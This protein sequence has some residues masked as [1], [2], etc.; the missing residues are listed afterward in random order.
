MAVMIFGQASSAESQTRFKHIPLQYI[1][2]LGDPGANAGGDAESW[3][4]WRQDPGPRGC[5]LENYK[6]LKD[7]KRKQIEEL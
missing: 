4:L 6:Q 2:A 7:K 1:V 5:R 3:G